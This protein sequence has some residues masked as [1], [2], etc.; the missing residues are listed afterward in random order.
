MQPTCPHP[1][2]LVVRAL[3]PLVEP[4]MAG[5]QQ[6]WATLRAQAWGMAQVPPRIWQV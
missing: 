3:A 5:F 6:V 1:Q 2:V 4:L